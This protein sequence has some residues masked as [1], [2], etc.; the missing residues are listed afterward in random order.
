MA[1]MNRDEPIDVFDLRN[2]IVP[3]SLLDIRHRFKK[4][5]PGDSLVVLW[6]DSAAADD[7]LRVLPASSFEIVSKGEIPGQSAGF[8]MELVKTRMG[9]ISLPGTFLFHK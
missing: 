4:M 2:A 5:Q 3:F 7:L 8:R 6:S 9:P 1:S